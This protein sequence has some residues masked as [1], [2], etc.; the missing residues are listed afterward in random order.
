MDAVRF[1]ETSVDLYN[2]KTI[3]IFSFMIIGM[4]I[5][6]LLYFQFSPI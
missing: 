2:V 1:T 5:S 4:I 6:D 3:K